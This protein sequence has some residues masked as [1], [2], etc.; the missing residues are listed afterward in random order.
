MDSNPTES[1]I[2]TVDCNWGPQ[3]TICEPK[4]KDDI[5]KLGEICVEEGNTAEGKIFRLC[6]SKCEWQL[7]TER[8]ALALHAYFHKVLKDQ[9]GLP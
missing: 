6:L 5:L 2:R 4:D 7:L 9:H 8:E 1:F 3:E